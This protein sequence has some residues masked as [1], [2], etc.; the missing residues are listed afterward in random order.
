M[1]KVNQSPVTHVRSRLRNAAEASGMTQEEIGLKM[2]FKKG[3]ARKAVSRLLN[4]SSEYDPRIS[5][6]LAFAKAIN[7]PLKAIL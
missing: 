6:L 4:P 7:K 3:G 2:G 1:A 5:T